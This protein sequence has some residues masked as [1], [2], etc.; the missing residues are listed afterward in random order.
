MIGQANFF[1]G[2]A[3]AYVAYMQ[4]KGQMALENARLA[5]QD[6]WQQKQHELDTARLASQEKY[7]TGS[8]ALQKQAQI[9]QDTQFNRTENRQDRNQTWTQGFSQQK[10]GED[11]RQFNATLNWRKLFDSANIDLGYKKLDLEQQSANDAYSLGLERNEIAS[12]GMDIE[13][14]AVKDKGNYYESEIQNNNTSNWMLTKQYQNKLVED[15]ATSLP[16]EIGVGKGDRYLQMNEQQLAELGPQAWE[17]IRATLYARGDKSINTEN[18]WAIP[19]HRAEYGT[20]KKEHDKTV[21]DVQLLLAA[22]DE[23]DTKAPE[24]AGLLRKTAFDLAQVYK[25]Q[26]GMNKRY[27]WKGVKKDDSKAVESETAEKPSDYSWQRM[28]GLSLSNL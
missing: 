8:L 14:Q 10:L 6:Q 16:K 15:I 22:A 23:A 2:A 20:T 12:K 24:Q 18:P 13:A 11:R 25:M 9:N 19:P 5:K 26:T 4:W 28:Q 17:Q 27:N 7:Q 1:D 21:S 3:G